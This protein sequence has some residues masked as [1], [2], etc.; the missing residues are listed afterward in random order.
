MTTSNYKK[1]NEMHIKYPKAFGYVDKVLMTAAEASKTMDD[2]D[3]GKLN[4]NLAQLALYLQNDGFDLR[5][6]T[7]ETWFA[8]VEIAY[9]N[10]KDSYKIIY[11]LLAYARG[12]R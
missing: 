7:F 4:S 12:E 2:K 11:M 8:E 6:G 10:W 9:P 1:I 5:P 3:I